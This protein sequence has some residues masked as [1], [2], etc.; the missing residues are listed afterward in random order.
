MIR[1]GAMVRY[2][3]SILRFMIFVL[4]VDNRNTVKTLC[5]AMPALRHVWCS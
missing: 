5:H 3:D 1:E 4:F 2:P